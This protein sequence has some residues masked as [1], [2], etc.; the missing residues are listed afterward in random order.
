MFLRKSPRL[1]LFALLAAALI[2]SS[3]NIGAQATP[4]VDINAINTAIVGTTIAQ[5]SAQFT[6]TALAVP[7]NTPAPTNTPQELPTFALPT[8]DTSGVTPLPTIAF[9]T[10][11]GSIIT[12]LP[13]FTQL[14]SPAA[15]VGV[16]STVT[17][18]NGCNDAAYLGEG[19]IKDGDKVKAGEKFSKIFMLQNTGTCKWDEGYSF[20]FI[21]ELST[22]GFQGYSIVL[23]KNKPEDYTDPGKGQTYILKLTAPKT[24]GTYKGYWKMKDD[25]GNPFGPLV[26]VEIVVE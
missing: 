1:T 22:P 17:T 7:T 3:C 5:F 26:W 19:G 24:A 20:A 8:L 23:A 16:V 15:T 12:P 21:A 11:P 10:T 18:K 4:T 6:Q 14:A 9:N 2:L 25:Q 13:A